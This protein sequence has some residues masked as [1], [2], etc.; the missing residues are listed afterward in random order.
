MSPLP[1][2][3]ISKSF[4]P[5]SDEIRRPKRTDSPSQTW[6]PISSSVKIDGTEPENIRL[7]VR[8]RTDLNDWKVEIPSWMPQP[9][10]NGLCHSP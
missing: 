3:P 6:C 1:K 8:V 10:G 5:V 9:F 7:P 2:S 4:S